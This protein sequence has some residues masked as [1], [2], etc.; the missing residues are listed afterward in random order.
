MKKIILLAL[1]LTTGCS[2]KFDVYD[3]KSQ[4]NPLKFEKVTDQELTF[5]FLKENIIAPKCL[6]CHSAAGPKKNLETYDLFVASLDEI[7]LNVSMD[8]MPPSKREPLTAE[9]KKILFRWI[10]LGAPE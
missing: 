4:L 1:L 3:F 9:E 5:A 2:D 6:E 8:W 7:D 10:E